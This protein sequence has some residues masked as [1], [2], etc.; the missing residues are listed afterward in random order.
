MACPWPIPAELRDQTGAAIDDL[1]NKT[2][3]SRI[4]SLHAWQFIGS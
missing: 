2:F 4:T 3:G 1:L